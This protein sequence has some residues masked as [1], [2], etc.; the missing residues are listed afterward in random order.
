MGT[1]APATKDTLLKQVDGLRDLIRRTKRLAESFGERD[2]RRS[3][4]R[5]A[6]QLEEHAQRLETLAAEARSGVVPRS[7]VL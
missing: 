1:D 2:E 4:L 5:Y 6:E 3:L 7:K